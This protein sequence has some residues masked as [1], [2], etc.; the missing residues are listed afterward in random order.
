MS[1]RYPGAD[2]LWKRIQQEEDSFTRH[3]LLVEMSDV[4]LTL[5]DSASSQQIDNTGADSTGI[6]LQYQ[7]IAN[8]VSARM[9]QALPWIDPDYK[10]KS[11]EQELKEVQE[12]LVSLV[13]ASSKTLKQ[14]QEL[15]NQKESLEKHKEKLTFKNEELRG[16]AGIIKNY[17]LEIKQL[18]QDISELNVLIEQNPEKK[19]Q[20]DILQIMEAFNPVLK[21]SLMHYQNIVMAWQVHLDQNNSIASA[22]NLN[23]NFRKTSELI[24]IPNLSRKISQL[25]KKYDQIISNMVS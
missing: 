8:H 22:L 2:D 11:L 19:Q 9:Q 6:L 18:E 3:E 7:E 12:M 20:K 14:V 21:K 23:S 24:K 16:V 5:D 4:L 1:R 10:G 13:A 15:K 25:L 17:K